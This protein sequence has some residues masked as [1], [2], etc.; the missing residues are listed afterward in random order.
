MEITQ[1]LSILKILECLGETIVRSYRAYFSKQLSWH[2]C[3]LGWMALV[4]GRTCGSDK[5]QDNK[6]AKIDSSTQSHVGR[7]AAGLSSRG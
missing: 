6:A 7:N 2:W 5:A 4:T 1:Q 3:Y